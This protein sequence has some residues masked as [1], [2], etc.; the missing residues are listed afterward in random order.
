VDNILA[1]IKYG[2]E[3]L[4]PLNVLGMVKAVKHMGE[5]K[6]KTTRKVGKRPKGSIDY[7]KPGKVYR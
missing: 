7:R 6:L 5:E 1:N 3:K 4:V 2:G